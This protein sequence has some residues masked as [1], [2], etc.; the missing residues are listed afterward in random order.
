M[1]SKS[2]GRDTDSIEDLKFDEAHLGP[3]LYLSYNLCSC[4]GYLLKELTKTLVV[5]NV[6]SMTGEVSD[7]GNYSGFIP[8]VEQRFKKR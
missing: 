5:P 1:Q 6:N 7:K 3:V 2:P 4:H 8:R